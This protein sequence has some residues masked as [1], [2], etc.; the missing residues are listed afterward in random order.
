MSEKLLDDLDNPDVSV[1]KRAIFTIGRKKIKEAVPKLIEL[2]KNDSDSVVRNSCARA[3][4]KISDSA[5]KDVVLEALIEALSDE[6]YYV[7]SNACW[8]LGKLKDPRAI[9]SLSKM[10]DPT[11]R[12]FTMAGDG[13]TSDSTT[14]KSASEQLK[15]EG[16]KYSDI[17]LEA[18]KAIG[19]IKSKKGIS[20]LVKALNDEGD[21][22]VRGKA[23]LALGKIRDPKAVQPLIDRLTEEKYWYVR[24]DIIQALEKFKS[25]KALP[26]LVKKTSDMYD[27]VRECAMDAILAIGEP[28]H[29]EILKLFFKMPSNSK[30][31]KY[32]K[33]NFSQQDLASMIRKFIDEAQSSDEK[34]KFQQFLS[35]I[36]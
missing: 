32:I 12:L 22:T 19:K 20:A 2:L 14:E 13:K 28:V 3:L 17:I 5:R 6:D 29:E 24:R 9:E 26:E 7:K 1:K 31:Q 25:P 4:G 35:K 8:S 18:I 21:G 16:V 23:A 36:V 33:N 10:V 34:Q 30:L 27:E 15:E 11:K